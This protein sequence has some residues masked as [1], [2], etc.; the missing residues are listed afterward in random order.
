MNRDVLFAL[1]INLLALVLIY[2][3]TEGFTLQTL[4]GAALEP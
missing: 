3:L 2:V 4:V 1:T